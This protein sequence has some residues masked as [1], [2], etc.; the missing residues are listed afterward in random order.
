MRK[1]LAQ[2]LVQAVEHELALHREYLALLRG[3]P[4]GEVGSE[5]DAE[6]DLD[7]AISYAARTRQTLLARIPGADATWSL[8]QTIDA[9]PSPEGTRLAE[10]RREFGRV[11]ADIA[12]ERRRRGL[13]VPGIAA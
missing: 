10:I 13:A 11:M 6:S 8:A 1:F 2:R 5:D 7:E 3:A 9:M 12:R 4:L